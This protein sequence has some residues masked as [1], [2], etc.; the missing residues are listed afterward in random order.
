[1]FYLRNTKKNLCIFHHESSIKH[2]NRWHP[3]SELSRRICETWQVTLVVAGGPITWTQGQLRRWSDVKDTADWLTDVLTVLCTLID[4]IW[5][6]LTYLLTYLLCL[7]NSATKSSDSEHN[8]TKGP[9]T[10]PQQNRTELQLWTCS[11]QSTT[12]V[13]FSVLLERCANGP[14]RLKR[15]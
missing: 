7:L 2:T 12:S 11:G 3:H 10:P 8:R 15:S 9:F 5:Y 13:F 4:L 14:L 6:L 1:M